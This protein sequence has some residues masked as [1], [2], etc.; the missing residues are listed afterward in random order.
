MS[1]QR[2]SVA[3]IGATGIAGQQFLACLAR[4]PWFKITAL[5]GS[6]RSA[7]KPY[8]EGIK[9]PSG[10][11]G[12]WA[13]GSVPDEFTGMVIRLDGRGVGRRPLGRRA[14]ARRHG[15][16][17]PL[18]R[19]RGGKGAARA[20][21]IFGVFTGGGVTAAPLAVSCTCTRVSVLEGHTEAVFADLGMPA[22]VDEVKA[23]M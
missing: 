11:T 23:A 15:Q 12:W 1:G 9:S 5:A 6:P 4:H 7:G 10:A 17:H 20:G 14:G 22:T 2:L 19:G 16:R 8:G 18:H 13:E 3:V 21:E